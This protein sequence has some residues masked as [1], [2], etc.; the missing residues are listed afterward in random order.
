MSELNLDQ[1][2]RD[3]AY[4]LWKADGGPDGQE[5][6]YWDQAKGSLGL[7]VPLREIDLQPS[8]HTYEGGLSAQP[9]IT[10]DQLLSSNPSSLS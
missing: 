4:Y 3:L 2:V 5:L 8:F 10:S 6:L 7:T 9:P 1:R